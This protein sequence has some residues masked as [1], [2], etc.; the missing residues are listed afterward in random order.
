MAYVNLNG[1]LHRN[2]E[3]DLDALGIKYHGDG[4]WSLPAGATVTGG[5]D[6]DWL[7]TLMDGNEISVYT[8]E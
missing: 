7:I 6:D 4:N 3:H 5:H 2:G 8:E 1:N